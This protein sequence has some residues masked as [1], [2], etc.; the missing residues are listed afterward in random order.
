MTRT[1]DALH[2]NEGRHPYFYGRPGSICGESSGGESDG[3]GECRAFR[4]GRVRITQPVRDREYC[5][6]RRGRVGR[7]SWHVRQ[8]IRGAP[9]PGRGTYAPSQIPESRMVLP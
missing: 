3:V 6:P 1:R 7:A 8:P 2:C 4:L 5:R 9:A